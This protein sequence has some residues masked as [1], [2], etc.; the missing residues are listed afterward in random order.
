MTKHLDF[1]AVIQATEQALIKT[2]YRRRA[3]GDERLQQYAERK[4]HFERNLGPI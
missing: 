2:V 1:K 4:I 3:P